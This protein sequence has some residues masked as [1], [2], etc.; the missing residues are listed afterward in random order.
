LTCDEKWVLY[1]APR[2]RHHWL[3]SH[4]PVPKQPN[5]ALHQVLL[6]VW[7]T[8]RRIVHRELLPAGQSIN[9]TMYCQQLSR[10]Q[11]KLKTLEPA[12]LDRK[13]LLQDNAK[14]HVARM[15]RDTILRLGWEALLHRPYSPDNAPSDFYLFYPLDNHLRGRQFKSL[16]EV[17][18]AL[19]TFVAS[20]P[21]KFYSDG[22]HGLSER[23]QKVVD[24]DGDYF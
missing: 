13:G 19:D 23:W 1:E 5:P 24:A 18:N 16:V 2:C 8:A 17:Q 9:A 7:W 22:I 10:V 21:T 14:P 11:E 20:R 12:L 3:A 6:C 15:T 4:E